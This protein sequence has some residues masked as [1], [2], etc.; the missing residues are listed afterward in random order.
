MNFYKSILENIQSYIIIK[1]KLNNVVWYND[2][3]A[4]EIDS[5]PSI[6]SFYELDN[7]FYEC[8]SRIIELKN[9]ECIL[10]EYRDVSK[11]TTNP[12][13]IIIM[14]SNIY[15]NVLRLYIFTELKISCRRNNPPVE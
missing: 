12:V 11:L 4:L 3:K 5:L 9:E 1:D 2:K 13:R 7:K 8:V 15:V 14:V 10:K 6:N